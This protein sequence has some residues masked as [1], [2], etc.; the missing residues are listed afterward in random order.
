MN[1]FFVN[2]STFY[3]C[4][5]NEVHLKRELTNFSLKNV[6][7]TV[8]K[9]DE[10]GCV[11]ARWLSIFS[12]ASRPAECDKTSLEVSSK[13]WEFF[14]ENNFCRFLAPLNTGESRSITCA[15]FTFSPHS[16]SWSG[17][18]SHKMCDADDFRLHTNR[19]RT[20]HRHI[21]SQ[22]DELQRYNGIIAGRIQAYIAP[23]LI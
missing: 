20:I 15:S 17:L 9:I 16:S 10:A 13:L 5:K 19:H 11:N 6:F 22:E 7:T 14:T 2:A 18:T 12:S 3:K 21:Y 1:P 8:Y 4:R 23:H